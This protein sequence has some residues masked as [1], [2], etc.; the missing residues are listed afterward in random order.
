MNNAVASLP[1]FSVTELDEIFDRFRRGKLTFPAFLGDAK[2]KLT[3]VSSFHS[4]PMLLLFS[5]MDADGRPFGKESLQ[6]KLY[7][8]Q[9]GLMALSLDDRIDYHSHLSGF[10][11]VCHEV[12]GGWRSSVQVYFIPRVTGV[13]ADSEVVFSWEESVPASV[14]LVIH[15]CGV[16]RDISFFGERAERLRLFISHFSEKQ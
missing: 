16:V 2:H 12:D 8:I 15:G 14:R 1:L 9:P 10:L 4:L 6:A 5:E 7:G 13:S 11:S 3:S